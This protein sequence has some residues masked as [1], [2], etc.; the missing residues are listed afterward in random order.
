MD[1]TYWLERQRDAIANARA[2]TLPDVRLIH[3]ELA[4][5]YSLKAAAAGRAQLK[6]TGPDLVMPVQASKRL[7]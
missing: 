5:R 2:A 4:D 3:Y 6:F 7:K 1:Q